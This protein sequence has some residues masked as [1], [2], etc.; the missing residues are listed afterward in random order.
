MTRLDEIEDEAG[1]SAKL[2]AKYANVTPADLAALVAVARAA[3][4]LTDH[5]GMYGAPDKY[6]EYD[7]TL[8]ALAPLLA[9]RDASSAGGSRD[10]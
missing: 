4:A 3:V 2:E 7:A 1:W 5:M 9:E 6:L 10:G 8:D